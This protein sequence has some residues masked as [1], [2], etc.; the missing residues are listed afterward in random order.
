MGL[1]NRETEIIR[2]LWK[3]PLS[4]TFYEISRRVPC[5]WNTAKKY[6]TNLLNKG[7]LEQTHYPRST[8]NLYTINQKLAEKIQN[9]REKTK[10][11]NT[12]PKRRKKHPL[13]RCMV[14]KNK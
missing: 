3:T 5:A 13:Q 10:N 4:L 8:K 2:V 14:S 12:L 1:R 6:T 11:N 7:Y 9:E